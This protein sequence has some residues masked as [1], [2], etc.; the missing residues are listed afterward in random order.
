MIKDSYP[1]YYADV[2]DIMEPEYS[3]YE[4]YEVPFSDQGSYELIRKIGRGK[5]S[6]VYEG[7]NSENDNY[8]VIKVLKPVKKSKIRREIKILD[9]LRGG[10]NIVKL[11][12][13]VRDHES[14]TPALIMEY[15]DTGELNFRDLYKSF[16]VP[17]IKY[18][19]YEIL[20]GLDYCHSKGVMHRDIK[21]HNIMIDHKKKKLRIIDWGLAEFYHKGQEYNVRVASRY[22]KG[23]ELLVGYHKYDYS[24]DMWSLGWMFAGIIFEREPFFKGDDNNDQ[25]VKIV[26][27]LGSEKFN[28]YVNKYKIELDPVFEGKLGGIKE[29]P[30]SYFVKKANNPIMTT[31][32]AVDLLDNMLQFDHAKRILPRDAMNHAYFKDLKER[33]KE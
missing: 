5:Y 9:T 13:V 4:N 23:P 31:D 12:D 21:P 11:I 25:L 3:D 7:I 14:K 29:K 16:T 6:D 2:C 27:V 17:D 15:V 26:K 18:Y 33:N 1:K 19:I 22:F 8:I 30:W 24:L 32:D 20:K 10:P 28:E